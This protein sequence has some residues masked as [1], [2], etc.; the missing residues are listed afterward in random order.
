MSVLFISC[1]RVEPQTLRFEVYLG[2]GLI[3]D[4]RIFK[5]RG[6]FEQL[7]ASIV[8]SL[9]LERRRRASKHFHCGIVQ[10]LRAI[11]IDLY[12]PGP[13]AQT[14]QCWQRSELI[15]R[16]FLEICSTIVALTRGVIRDA[17]AVSVFSYVH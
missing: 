16:Q 5:A 12:S 2:H 4:D 13:R 14:S 1:S 15:L 11:P 17:V 7:A 9:V 6:C 10:W 3:W 8:I